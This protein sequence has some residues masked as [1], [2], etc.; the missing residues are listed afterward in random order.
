M[1]FK[2]HPNLGP[3][4]NLGPIN[5][6]LGPINPNPSPSHPNQDQG[7]ELNEILVNSFFYKEFVKKDFL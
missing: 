2:K 4:P 3:K 5:P 7:G 1:R 6:N